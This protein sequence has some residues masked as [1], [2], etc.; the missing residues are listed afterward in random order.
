MLTLLEDPALR[1]TMGHVSSVLARRYDWQV[2]LPAYRAVFEEALAWH[3][4]QR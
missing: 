1:A 2:I 4:D 3:R